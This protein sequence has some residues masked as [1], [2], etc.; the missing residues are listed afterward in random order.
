MESTASKPRAQPAGPWRPLSCEG[1]AGTVARAC[2][3]GRSIPDTCGIYNALQRATLTAGFSPGMAGRIGHSSGAGESSRRRSRQ[4]LDRRRPRSALEPFR[5]RAG[6]DLRDVREKKLLT[7]G[8][9][10]VLPHCGQATLALSCS[11]MERVTL[12]SRR[13]LSQ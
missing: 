7:N 3:G 5:A 10:A 13:Q 12:T 6:Q 2:H 1:L 4:E 9:S 11:L 8:R